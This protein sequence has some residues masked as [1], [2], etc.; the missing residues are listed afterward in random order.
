MISMNKSMVEIRRLEKKYDILNSEGSILS[1]YENRE[2]QFH[3]ASLVQG[4]EG[5]IY[6][7]SN[8]N[9]IRD[10]A[11]SKITLNE[12]LEKSEEVLV[13][14]KKGSELTTYFKIDFLDRLELGGKY[15]K[16]IYKGI[17]NP[18]FEKEFS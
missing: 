13:S 17:K 15:F 14:L 11:N 5:T 12:L 8:S 3:I 6:Y 1:L 18:E 4:G 16:D 10:Y 7:R 2:G 9:E